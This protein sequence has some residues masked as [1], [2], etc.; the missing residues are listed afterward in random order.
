MV[1]FWYHKNSDGSRQNLRFITSFGRRKKLD[2]F[3]GITQ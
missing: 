3:L 1:N 2:V